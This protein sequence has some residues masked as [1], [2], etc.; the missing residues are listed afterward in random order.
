MPAVSK[1]FWSMQGCKIFLIRGQNDWEKN[2]SKSS[3]EE[4][5]LLGKKSCVKV[6]GGEME[7]NE[8]QNGKLPSPSVSTSH[9]PSHSHLP[10]LFPFSLPTHTFPIL[11]SHPSLSLLIITWFPRIFPLLQPTPLHIHL[12]KR[13]KKGLLSA[14][15]GHG[16]NLYRH[17]LGL[18]IVGIS[19]WHIIHSMKTWFVCLFLRSAVRNA[20]N[21]TQC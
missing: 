15:F 21:S 8:E 18:R 1:S 11:T 3:W 5:K 9:V 16:W 20:V 13:P 10:L 7:E 17:E 12:Q 2:K 6:G 4:I 14:F 19:S